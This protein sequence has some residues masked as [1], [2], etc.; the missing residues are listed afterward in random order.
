MQRFLTPADYAFVIRDDVLHHLEDG[1]QQRLLRAELAATRIMKSLLYNRYDIDKI[2][3]PLSEYESGRGYVTGQ[4]VYWKAEGEP[5]DL[6]E[7]Y[8]AVANTNGN[9]TGAGWKKFEG[10]NAM[11][12]MYLA[13]IAIY[14]FLAADMPG[15]TTENVKDRHREAMAWLKSVGSGEGDSNLPG[16]EV[17]DND[18]D[19][20]FFSHPRENEMW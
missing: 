13:D 14:H 10:R 9:P 2:F 15:L 5:D 20:R 7:V 19:F 12:M 8:Q 1:S 17:D 6:Y 11:V 3:F 16:R 18:G 4:L